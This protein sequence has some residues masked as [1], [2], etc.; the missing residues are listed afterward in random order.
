MQLTVPSAEEDNVA[1]VLLQELEVVMALNCGEEAGIWGMPGHAGT[2]CNIS[3]HYGA[4]WD[5][6]GHA[7]TS[8]KLYLEHS[9]TLWYCVEH[10]GTS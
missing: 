3:G 4:C 7:G 5:I 9:R 10:S 6:L 8:Q 2:L 1:V